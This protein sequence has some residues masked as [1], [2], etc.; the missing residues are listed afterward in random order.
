MS[1]YQRI[2]KRVYE[3]LG[4][5]APGDK[6]SLA[7]D[8]FVCGLVLL[9]SVA[10]VVEL[11]GVPAPIQYGLEVFE[12]IVVGIFVVEYLLRLW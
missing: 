12:N 2:K 1:N 11:I 7:V 5:A 6:L 8:I 4:P 3:V 9:S 10:V